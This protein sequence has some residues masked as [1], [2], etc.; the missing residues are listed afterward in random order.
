[1]GLIAWRRLRGAGPRPL[2]LLATLASGALLLVVA[3]ALMTGASPL[4]TVSALTAALVAH[5]LDI[6]VRWERKPQP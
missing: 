1:M 4:W 3:R 6:A 5:G 2:A